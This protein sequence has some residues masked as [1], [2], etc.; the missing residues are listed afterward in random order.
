MLAAPKTNEVEARLRRV[1][2]TYRWF[3]FR[4]QPVYGENKVLVGW[5][6]TNDDIEDRKRAENE[7]RIKEQ[8]YREL[9]SYTPVG[10]RRD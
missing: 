10:L 6:G 3:L 7:L 2:G 4:A 1:D 5:H 9:F 8:R